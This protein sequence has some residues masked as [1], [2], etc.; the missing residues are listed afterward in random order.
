MDKLL[1]KL[2]EQ[3]AAL[4]HQNEAF[5]TGEE[6][7]NA[8]I[9]YPRNLDL[10]SSSSSLPMTPATDAFPATAPTTRPASTALDEARPEA[11]EV[12]R[13]KL[14]L[15]QAQNH[16]SKLDQE[17]AKSRSAK[18]E[19][20]L[21]GIGLPRNLPS[22][23]RETT[24]VMADDAQSDSSDALS[25][26][27]FNRARGIWGTSKGAFN[28]NALPAP[29]NEPSPGNWG[30]G[31]GFNQGYVEANGPYPNAMECYRGERPAPDHDLLMRPPGGRRHNRYDN[32]LGTPHQ[33]GGG[34]GGMGAPVNQFNSMGGPMPSS[35]LNTTPGLGPTGMG[36]YPPYQQQPVGTTLSPHASEFTSKAGWKSEVSKSAARSRRRSCI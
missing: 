36:V 14:Q 26:T 29:V 24:W 16:I 33:F 22:I 34:F 4:N 3:Q 5:R 23:S 11:E 27:A 25:A 2:S 30:A 9:M 6:D 18:A 13:L 21:Q 20:D 19:P 7:G 15:A 17:L 31:R 28:N 8:S 35:A 12:L 10:G 32:R 1:A